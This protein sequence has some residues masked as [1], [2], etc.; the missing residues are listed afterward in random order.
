MYFSQIRPAEDFAFAEPIRRRYLRAG[1]YGPHRLVWLLFG[2]HPDRKR[3]FVYRFDARREDHF[4]CHVVSAREPQPVDGLALR[5]KPYQPVLKAGDHLAF[6]LRANPT[7]SRRGEDGRRQRHDVLMDAKVQTRERD[8]DAGAMEEAMQTAAFSWLRSRAEAAGFALVDETLR[9]ISY[10]PE[11]F[12]KGRSGQ[13][14]SL[15]VADYAGELTV[16]N[17][18]R[19]CTTLAQGLGHGKAFG[20]GLLLVRPAG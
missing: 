4:V 5:A 20:C 9:L 2:D 6:S 17:P 18:E 14:V 11:R 16:C 12:R 15:G 19:F 8:A 1:S 10:R 13:E 3:D 7:V